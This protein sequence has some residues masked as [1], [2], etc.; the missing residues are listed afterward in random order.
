MTMVSLF[1]NDLIFSRY[2]KE[3]SKGGLMSKY[4]PL[5]SYFENAPAI[6]QEISLSFTQIE[7]LLD[8][9]LPQSAKNHRAWWA[10]DIDGRHVQSYSWMDAGWKVA[11]VDLTNGRVMFTRSK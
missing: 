2:P 4:N 10:N 7:I 8:S 1:H 11:D 5:R 9:H 3:Y 6:K